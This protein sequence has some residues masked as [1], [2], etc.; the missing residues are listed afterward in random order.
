MLPQHSQTSL[1]LLPH[2]PSPIVLA[3]DLCDLCDLLN[4]NSGEAGYSPFTLTSRTPRS[5]C[6][7]PRV[8][9]ASES[10]LPGR[11]SINPHPPDNLPWDDLDEDPL[12]AAYRVLLLVNGWIMGKWVANLGAPTSPSQFGV[13]HG[14]DAASDE[15]APGLPVL[16]LAI[17]SAAH[18]PS[19]ATRHSRARCTPPKSPAVRVVSHVLRAVIRHP[20]PTVRA[21]G[22]HPAPA[23]PPSPAT[24]SRFIQEL[25]AVACCPPPAH[26]TCPCRLLPDAACKVPAGECQRRRCPRGCP[27]L[28]DDKC[29]RARKE[30]QA[31]LQR[32]GEAAPAAE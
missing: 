11:Y 27:E 26:F 6:L 15:D 23:T 7:P 12:V 16:S 32:A 10:S 30:M 8:S 31:M 21:P 2:R 4:A 3:P 29:A 17:P 28:S 20:L 24:R 9:S 25:R 18:R 1:F 19:S 14:W 5:T 22:Q 13:A